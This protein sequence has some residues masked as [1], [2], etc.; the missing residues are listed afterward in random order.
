VPYFLSEEKGWTLNTQELGQ[1]VRA[2]R[3]NGTTIRAMVV[4]NPGNPTGAV[5]T[6]DTLEE[7]I[8]F[9]H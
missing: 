1:I 9:C 5:Y 3:D 4:I 6:Q 2:A 7:I 8:K